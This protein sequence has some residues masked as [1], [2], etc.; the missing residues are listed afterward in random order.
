MKGD[1]EKKFDEQTVAV[2]KAVA[3][4][5]GLSAEEL[6]KQLD[7]KGKKTM[8]MRKSADGKY[9][10]IGVDFFSGED[11]VQGEYKTPE[12]ALGIA[13]KKTKEAMKNASSASVATVYYAYGPDG[14][15]LGGDEC[16]NKK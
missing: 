14:N 3:A 4:E 15:Y 8:E 1:Y 11:W 5:G 16:W 9:K 7:E 2:A 6:L 10:V 13:K 12:K